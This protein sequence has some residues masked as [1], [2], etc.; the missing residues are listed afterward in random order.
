[1]GMSCPKGWSTRGPS[2][3]IPGLP[4]QLVNTAGTWTLAQ[5]TWNSWWILRT[6]GPGPNSH[7]T[8]GQ[9]RGPSDLGKSRLG[10]LVNPVG[11]LA[12]A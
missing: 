12:R 9:P 6:L 4:G 8:A 5:V 1:M 11:P 7:G 3:Q 10:H 2:N